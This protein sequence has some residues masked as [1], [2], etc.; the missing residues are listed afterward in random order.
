MK[1]GLEQE[2]VNE[3][4]RNI[5]NERHLRV[6]LAYLCE[7]F[8]VPFCDLE[9]EKEFLDIC[10]RLADEVDKLHISRRTVIIPKYAGEIALKENSKFITKEHMKIAEKRARSIVQQ[11]LEEKLQHY[12]ER[13]GIETKGE[14][15]GK[16]N[17]VA[18]AKEDELEFTRGLEDNRLYE[19]FGGKDVYIGAQSEDRTGYLGTIV[20][21]VYPVKGLKGK[22][23]IIDEKGNLKMKQ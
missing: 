8:K 2:V 20:A 4:E 23:E 18:I 3:I 10:S 15:V 7:R 21:Y 5:K 17:V 9:A 13:T 22:F 6:Y 12:I 11:L 14:K 19:T 1:Y 16:V